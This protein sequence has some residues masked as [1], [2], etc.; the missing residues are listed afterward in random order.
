MSSYEIPR[1]REAMAQSR[2]VLSGY[3]QP[4][5][6]F[7]RR[8]LAFIGVDFGSALSDIEAFVLTEA[9]RLHEN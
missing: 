1:R 7:R 3:W 5:S 9:E 2:A 4:R 8:L 6:P